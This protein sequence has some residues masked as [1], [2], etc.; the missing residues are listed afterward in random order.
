MAHRAV[1]IETAFCGERYPLLGSSIGCK[2]SKTCPP[3]RGLGD[4]IDRGLA[5]LHALEERSPRRRLNVVELRACNC[6]W[7]DE[8]LV[9]RPTKGGEDGQGFDVRALRGKRA[10][11]VTWLALQP[12]TSQP[13]EVIDNGVAWDL[14]PDREQR[15]RCDGNAAREFVGGAIQHEPLDRLEV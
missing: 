3:R 6:L 8:P 11:H 10:P 9:V 2:L 13:R 5:V 14:G 4:I 7:V 1:V 15:E 12:L